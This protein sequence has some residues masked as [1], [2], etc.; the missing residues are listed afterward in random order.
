MWQLRYLVRTQNKLVT[1]RAHDLLAFWLVVLPLGADKDEELVA[2]ALDS[3]YVSK[4]QL[5]VALR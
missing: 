4:A 2:C 3:L 5:N 1:D